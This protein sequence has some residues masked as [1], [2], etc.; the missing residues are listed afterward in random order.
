MPVAGAEMVELLLPSHV[1]SHAVQ[2]LIK[3]TWLI[4]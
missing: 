2:G 3:T 4:A 1:W